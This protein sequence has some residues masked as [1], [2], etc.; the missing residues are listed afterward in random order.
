MKLEQRALAACVDHVR[1]NEEIKSLTATIHQALS[2][3]PGID[4]NLRA[5]IDFTSHAAMLEGAERA[6]ADCTH[7]SAALEP[8]IGDHG[9]KVWPY[10]DQVNELVSECEHCAAAFAAIQQRK[11]ARKKF[12]IVRRQI[13]AI[14]KAAAKESTHVLG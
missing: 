12:G 2:A 5:P 8:E 11:A 10:A 6:E 1:L 14:G 3:C 4:G 7:L 9:F 13:A